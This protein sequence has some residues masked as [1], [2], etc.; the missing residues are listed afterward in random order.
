MKRLTLL[1]SLLTL[2]LTLG[3]CAQANPSNSSTGGSTRPEIVVE[4]Q[5]SLLLALEQ[6]GASAEAVDTVEQVFFAPQGS[7]IAVNGVDVQVF[8][9]ESGQAME[10]EAALVAPDGGSIGTNMVTWIDAPHFYK[11]GRII[12][13]YVGSDPATIELLESLLGPQFAGR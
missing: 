8:E 11:A 1:V 6:A 7:I 13:L 2:A 5:A 3:A 9:Y 4:D 12:V 10:A